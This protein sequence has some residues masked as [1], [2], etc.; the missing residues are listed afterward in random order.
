MKVLLV[1]TSKPPMGSSLPPQLL[2]I[3]AAALS[4]LRRPDKS[5]LLWVDALCINQADVG[6]RQSQVER[7]T[8][9]YR[10]AAKV[11]VWLGSEAEDS[12]RAM[13]FL[14]ELRSTGDSGKIQRY[15]EAKLRSIHSVLDR[16]WFERI[17]IRQEVRLAREASMTCG[18]SMISG[19]LFKASITI[20]REARE[21]LVKEHVTLWN[22]I[23]FIFNLFNT[24]LH[25]SMFDLL[26]HGRRCK[27]TDPR[28]RI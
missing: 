27:R 12:S 24:S 7:M 15:S 11:I 18:S 10:Y 21:F 16:R 17:W 4:Q 23:N 9:I 5:R 13:K 26:Q 25:A 3:L 6:E 22:R 19:G 14:T 20:L 1:F 2:K 28:D 8:D